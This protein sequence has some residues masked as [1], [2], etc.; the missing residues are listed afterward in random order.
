MS[1]KRYRLTG[2][3][4]VNLKNI[5]IVVTISNKYYKDGAIWVKSGKLISDSFLVMILDKLRFYKLLLY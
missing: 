3:E 4:S 2:L 1:K 5:A